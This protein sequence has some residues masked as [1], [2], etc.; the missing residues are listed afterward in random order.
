[1]YAAFVG[2]CRRQAGLD[3]FGRVSMPAK[4]MD[5]NIVIAL[6]LVS[7]WLLMAGCNL[8]QLVLP[9]V[10]CLMASQYVERA[11]TKIP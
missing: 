3:L 2:E 5:D 4:R 7:I 8:I 9:G 1:M 10:L 11:L 6:S